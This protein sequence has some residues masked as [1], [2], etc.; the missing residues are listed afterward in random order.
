MESRISRECVHSFK[1]GYLVGMKWNGE[2]YLGEEPGDENEERWGGEMR[3]RF[4]WIIVRDVRG[5]K[6]E[7]SEP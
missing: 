3:V 2:R 1:G 5:E 4:E 6:R 7:E